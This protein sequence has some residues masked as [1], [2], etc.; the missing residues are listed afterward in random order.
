MLFI[1][2]NICEGVCK[3]GFL[4]NCFV[5]NSYVVAYEPVKEKKMKMSDNHLIPMMQVKS[6]CTSAW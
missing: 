1:V 4:T 5:L 2:K 6:A 3:F